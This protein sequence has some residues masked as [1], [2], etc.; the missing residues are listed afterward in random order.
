MIE[1]ISANQQTFQEVSFEPGLNIILAERL[2]ESTQ[3][4][5]RNGLGKSTLVEIMNFCLGADAPRGKGLCIEPLEDWVFEMVLSVAGNIVKVSREISSPNRIFIEGPTDGWVYKPEFDRKSRQQCLSLEKWRKLLGWAFFGLKDNSLKYSPSYRSLISY[6]VRHRPSAYN[7]PFRHYPQQ[8]PWNV[9]INAGFLIGLNWEYAAK[10]QDLKDKEKNLKEMRKA[11]RSGFMDEVWGTMGKM[12]AELVRLKNRER[13]EKE[14]LAS[15]NV[16]PQYE[17]IQSKANDLTA[18]IHE[19]TNQNISDK[20]K[21]DLYQNAVKSEKSPSETE[22]EKLYESLGVHFSESIRKTLSDARIFHRQIVQNRRAFLENEII[23]IERNTK[24]RDEEIRN[25]TNERAAILQILQTHGALQEM[26]RMQEMYVETKEKLNRVISRIDSMKEVDSIS[27]DIKTSKSDLMKTAEL[28]Y[29][30]RH[31]ILAYAIQFYADNSEALYENP[32][33]LVIDITEAGYKY[34]VEIERSGSSGV[35]KMKVFCFDHMILQLAQQRG[36]GID[37]LI[38]DS[39]LYDGVDSRQK[40]LAIEYA[41]KISEENG[42]QYICML[43]SDMVPV[44]D[45]SHGFDWNSYVRLKLTDKDE[46]GSLLGFRFER[47]EK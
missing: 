38:H 33:S 11:F 24:E 47:P 40:A 18:E 35:E 29:E 2:D 6:F 4:D 10:W 9:Q 3:K 34:Q 46:S 26:N 16:H 22:I 1:S 31:E 28:D 30:Q 41:A 7:D 45:F 15:F 42:S 12:R 23:R 14:A 8:S 32:G 39:I 20:R 19:L 37:F 25:L 5:T 17:S 27:R 13:I 21:L 43:N 36:S 44:K